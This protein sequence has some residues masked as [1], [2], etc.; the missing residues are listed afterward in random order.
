V[1]RL[2][3]FA[4]LLSLVSAAHFCA[5]A[6]DR[7]NIL[8]L[9]AEDMSCRLGC[10]GDEYAVTPNIDRLCD[11]IPTL[12]FSVRFTNAF[13]IAPVCTPARS[14]LITGVYSSSLGSQHLRGETVL[15]KGIRCYSELL[16][17]AGYYCTN[18]V[19][20]DYNFL[21]PATAWDESSGKAHWRGKKEG[22]PFFAIFNFVT[23]HQSRVRFTGEQRKKLTARLTPEQFHDPAE[24]PLPP[25]YPDTPVVRQ[26]VAHMYDNI[27]AMDYQV[28][29]LLKQLDEDGLADDTIVF[30]Y[31]DHGDGMP[32]GKRW[33]YD[34]GTRVPLII[35][36]PDK[37]RHLLPKA[38]FGE[39]DRMVT[40]ADLAPTLLSL[41]GVKI[42]QHMR[43]TAFLGPQT[44][45]STDYV[46]IIR[47]RVDEVSEFTRSV[48]HKRYRYVRN[49]LP[50]RP[51]L[52]HSDFSERTN[53]RKEFRRL[54]AEGKLTGPAAYMMSPT[55]PAEELYDIENDPHEINN[56]A[57]S[58]ERQQIL[59]ELRA[60]LFAWMIETRD[61]SLFPEADM[62]RRLADP[63]IYEGARKLEAAKFEEI[64][65]AADLVGRGDSTIQQFVAN[66]KSDDSAVRFW[67]AVG[68]TCIKGGLNGSAVDALAGAL[69]DPVPTVRIA[70]AEALCE[71]GN[72]EAGLPVLLKEL[73]GD[74]KRVRLAAAAGVVAIGPAARG[75]AEELQ[76][77]LAFLAMRK[78]NHSL[79]SRWALQYALKQI[80]E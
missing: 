16:R 13:A 61:T 72:V 74:D 66:L 33:V 39:S 31:S 35:R 47:D 80:G 17:E 63:T 14:C 73:I 59:E 32:R 34:S 41:T 71:K 22:Q 24:A 69:A 4:V 51:V 3:A 76:A 12:Y 19:K 28:G 8:W 52:Q 67:G 29:D 15:P 5:A 40:F 50:H 9:T 56:L 37:Y 60:K 30:F 21:T 58:P 46:Y 10:Y 54:A 25:Y 70:A 48:R 26:D 79:Y 44:G 43:G 7:P 23:T 68:L 18:N 42:P 2:H 77:A 55:K 11:P 45:K 49:F 27:T 75:S 62:H 1:T 53:T 6:E 38:R 20:E 64:L 57:E 36:F 65:A 78:D